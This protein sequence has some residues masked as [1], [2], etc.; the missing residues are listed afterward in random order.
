[1]D[2][3][4]FNL[5]GRTA[6][7]T[8]G[9]RGNGKGICLALAQAGA[10]VV[11]A[12]LDPSTAQATAKEVQALGQKALAIPTDVCQR[13]QVEQ[14][15][16]QTVQAFGTIDVLVNNAGGGSPKQLVAGLEMSEDTWDAIVDLN[17]KSVFLCTQ[18]AA[19]VMIPHKKGN[20]VN[21]A[22]LAGIIPY[23]PGIHYGVA[24]AGVINLTMN[25]AVILGPHN[26]RVNAIAPG[27]IVTENTNA[28]AYKPHP[29][30]LELR[31]RAVPRGRLGTPEDVGWLVAFLASDASD[32]INGETIR[33]DGALP[34]MVGLFR[35]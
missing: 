16:H 13:D 12:E 32:Y 15:V 5:A 24:K 28:L 11:V 14:M 18:A 33:M 30:L 31:A 23:T 2:L 34:S 20:I 17:L 1:M 9:G 10:D 25:V 19:R 27:F 35:V 29:E 26:I 6:V 8:G 21:I 3:S 22:S 7:V 4:K